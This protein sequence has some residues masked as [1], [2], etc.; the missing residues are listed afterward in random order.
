MCNIYVNGNSRRKER[1]KAI[2]ET[3]MTFNNDN[4]LK[5]MSDTKTET[6]EAQRTPSRIYTKKLPRT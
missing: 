3:I 1:D 4:V 2:C 5:L 6:Q